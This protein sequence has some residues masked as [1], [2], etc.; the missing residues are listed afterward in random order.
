VG[1]VSTLV[2][3]ENDMSF[4]IRIVAVVAVILLWV[5]YVF[6]VYWSYR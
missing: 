2:A 3:P 5:G 1:Q 4:R 6:L